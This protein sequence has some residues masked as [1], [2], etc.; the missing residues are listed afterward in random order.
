M[1]QKCKLLLAIS[2][3]LLLLILALLA[4][5]VG[6][7]IVAVKYIAKTYWQIR[8]KFVWFGSFLM[9]AYYFKDESFFDYVS[10]ASLTWL[11]CKI[12]NRM[13]TKF[14]GEELI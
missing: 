8:W 1:V 11:T 14:V 7:L 10:T 13:E 6:T 4:R 5:I 12:A 9:M 2:A 3:G